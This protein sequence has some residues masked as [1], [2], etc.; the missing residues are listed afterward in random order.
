M[1][2]NK[3]QVWPIALSLVLHL[4][5]MLIFA[6]GLHFDTSTIEPEQQ[7]EIIQATL[8]EEPLGA[9]QVKTADATE[10]KV[11]EPPPK[12]NRPHHPQNRMRSWKSGQRKWKPPNKNKQLLN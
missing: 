4:L 10:K 1:P 7:P 6:L 8:I 2:N 12:V 5:L 3:R 11:V 9:P